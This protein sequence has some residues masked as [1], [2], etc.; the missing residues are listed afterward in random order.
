MGPD[1]CRPVARTHLLPKQVRVLLQESELRAVS[2]ECR[3]WITGQ[4]TPSHGIFPQQRFVSSLP[5]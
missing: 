3:E 4:R 2:G 1:V 5:V